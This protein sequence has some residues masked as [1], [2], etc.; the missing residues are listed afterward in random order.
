MTKTV[1]V[2][3]SL[4]GQNGWLLD[5]SYLIYPATEKSQSRIAI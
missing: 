5:I 4:Y 2:A 3:R 1:I